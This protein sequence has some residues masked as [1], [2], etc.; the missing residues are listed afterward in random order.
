[1]KRN[2][3]KKSPVPVDSSSSF[4]ETSVHC[5]G[6]AGG[7]AADED[8]TKQ[9]RQLGEKSQAYTAV[10]EEEVGAGA[11]RVEEADE[12]EVAEQAQ[13]VKSGGST[14]GGGGLDGE[15]ADGGWDEKRQVDRGETG[16]VD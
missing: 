8:E 12:P 11:V 2:A 1:M 16:D 7:G 4:M 10:I 9:D 3:C 5:A 15:G 14:I 13:G 6:K